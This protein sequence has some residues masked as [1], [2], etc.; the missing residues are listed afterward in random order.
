MK[1][2]RDLI[3]ITLALLG[4]FYAHHAKATTFTGSELT[5]IY[6]IIQYND[7]NISRKYRVIHIANMSTRN[8]YTKPPSK[9]GYKYYKLSKGKMDFIKLQ[10]KYVANYYKQYGINYKTLMTMAAIESG[11][12]QNARPY[13]IVKYRGKRHRKYLSSARNIMQVVGNTEKLLRKL[14]PEVIKIGGKYHSL[15]DTDITY[16]FA[17]GAVYIIDNTKYLRNHGYKPTIRNVYLAHNLGKRAVILLNAEKR[18]PNVKVSRILGNRI[19]SN[20]KT[21]YTKPLKKRRYKVLTVAVA[22]Q[23]I[24]NKLRRHQRLLHI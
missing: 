21:L 5:T 24:Q 14:H 15:H 13:R 3:L 4:I 20:N 22:L 11:F 6:R 16:S 23:N 7:I 8:K 18:S 1:L 9:L 2:L 10:A 12:K 17:L 19:V